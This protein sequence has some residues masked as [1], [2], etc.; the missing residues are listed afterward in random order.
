MQLLEPVRAGVLTSV[1]PTDAATD[2]YNA[3]LQEK[4]GGFVWSQYASW[5]RAGAD[6]RGRIIHM[7]PG[8]LVLLW[9]WLRRVRWEDYEV[10]GPGAEEW[11]RSRARGWWLRRGAQLVTAVLVGALAS[12]LHFKPRVRS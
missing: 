7:F 9:W 10:E 8:P 4:L 12:I 1:A 11:R 3:T 2:R 5:Y 6:G